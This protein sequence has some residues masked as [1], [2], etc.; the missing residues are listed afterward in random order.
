MDEKILSVLT[1]IRKHME[2][3]KKQLFT[4]KLTV[5]TNWS[6]GG[7]GKEIDVIVKWK[8]ND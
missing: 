7:I 8:D 5:E 1:K 2:L 6:P 4:G 3:L